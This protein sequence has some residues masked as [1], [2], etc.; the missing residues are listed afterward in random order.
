MINTGISRD[1]I[2]AYCIGASARAAVQPAAAMD[3]AVID[4]YMAW[5][6]PE[7]R[8]AEDLS[9][10]KSAWAKFNGTAA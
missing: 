1:D 2:R 9:A 4:F 6:N 3:E 5:L 10:F 7:T 8:P